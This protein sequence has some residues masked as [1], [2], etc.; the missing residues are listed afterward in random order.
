MAN[1]C[2]SIREE[3]RERMSWRWMLPFRHPMTIVLGASQSTA[4]MSE[5]DSKGIVELHVPHDER[6][7]SNMELE[8]PTAR[9]SI[10]AAGTEL[11][12]SVRGREKDAGR[13]FDAHILETPLGVNCWAT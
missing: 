5:A 8:V 2:L 6:L 3:P 13:A 4:S 9:F 1:G 12:D 10:S 11:S 7:N